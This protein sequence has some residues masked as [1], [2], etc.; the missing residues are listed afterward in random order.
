MY[1]RT[2]QVL[3]GLERA[4]DPNGDG[5]AHDAAR[6]AVVGVAEPY[7]AFA[8]GPLAK[9]VAGAFRLDTLVVAPAGNDGLGASHSALRD[10]GSVAGPGGAPAALTVG[11]ADL[12][13]RARDVRVTV[14]AGLE[15]AFQD[16]VPLGGAV[17]AR[18]TLSLPSPRRSRTR[19]LHA[20]P[21]LRSAPSSTS[22]ASATSPG[23]RR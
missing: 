10:S 15:L 13:R 9:A 17:A 16:R 23:R 6:I 21:P 7:S 20:R 22:G 8:E 3:A 5:I 4:V 18:R 19:P 2:D 12:R 11:A 1:A 14:R